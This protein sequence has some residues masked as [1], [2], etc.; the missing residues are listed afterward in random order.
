M[1]CHPI[2]TILMISAKNLQLKSLADKLIAFKRKLIVVWLPRASGPGAS[3]WSRYAATP[4][5][6]TSEESVGLV[7][8]LFAD[9]AIFGYHQR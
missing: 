1:Q 9:P 4:S 3:C 7:T 8:S 6:P 2:A 5:P